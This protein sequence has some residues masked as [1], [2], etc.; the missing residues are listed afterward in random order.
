MDMHSS[1]GFFRIENQ[2]EILLDFTLDCLLKLHFDSEFD[3]HTRHRK[4]VQHLEIFC[5][6]LC[7]HDACMQN[8]S[9]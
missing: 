6:I 2:V 4:V 7:A 8:I 3:Q 1:L 5:K 9:D